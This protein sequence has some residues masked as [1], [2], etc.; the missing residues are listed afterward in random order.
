[1]ADVRATQ[2]LAALPG[3][4]EFLLRIKFLWEKAEDDWVLEDKFDPVRA[5]RKKGRGVAEVAW[6]TSPG[7]LTGIDS[8]FYQNAYPVTAVVYSLY[9]LRDPDPANLAPLRDGD[10]KCVAQRVV[11]H[12]EGALRGQR[13]TPTRRQKIQEWE[14]RIHETGASVD[15]VA[16]LEKILKRAI[17]LRDIAGE[18]IYNSGK[19]QR[20]DN[21]VRGIVELICHNGH[22]WPKDLHFP[23]SRE[24]HING[25]LWNLM[26]Y[27]TRE[28]TSV[29]MKAC[30]PASFKG[31]GEAKPYFE[32][33]GHL[34]H[35]MTRVAINGPLPKDI[36]TGFAEV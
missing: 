25:S 4:M 13:L 7:V 9:P 8:V 11:E 5:D 28:V 12:F 35:R 24:V 14:E 26:G 27:D 18:D 33:F 20:G 36:G 29:N 16:E 2:L 17:I 3:G 31:M 21:G 10:L 34:T 15:D 30:Y 32:Q 23:Q 6:N 19:Y 1:M 22:T